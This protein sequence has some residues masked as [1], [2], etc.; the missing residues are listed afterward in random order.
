MKVKVNGYYNHDVEIVN[1]EITVDGQITNINLCRLAPRHSHIIF[2]NRS[3]NIELASEDRSAKIC[4]VK[5]NGTAY[6]VSLE[7][8]YD[9]LLKQLGF[10]LAQSNK[11]QEIKAPMPGLV[12]KVLAIPGMEVKKG[13]S[14]L[15]LEAMKM[16]NMIKSPTDGIVKNISV[17]PGDKVEKNQ[18]LIQFS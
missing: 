17:I 13:D 8:D 18:I 15:I 4:V 16:E 2:N 6:Q 1:D 9:V 12:L 5:V 14:M 7:D 11:V 3:Y 10:D